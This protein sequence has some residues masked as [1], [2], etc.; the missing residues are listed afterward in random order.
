MPTDMSMSP[1]INAQAQP[2]GPEQAEQI[3]KQRFTE[4][5]YTVLSSRF[6]EL[7]P[8]VVTFKILEVGADVGTGIGVFILD[9]NG[10]SIY[11]PIIMTDSKL[12]PIEM[13]YYKDLNIFLPL[14]IPWLDEVGKMSLDEMG[15]ASELPKEVPQDVN[16]RNVVRPPLSASGRYGYASL[17]EQINH[18]AKYMFKAAEDQTLNVQPQFLNILKNAPK[19][20]LDGVKLAFQ[21]RPFLLQK[22]ANNYGKEG[23]INAMRQGYTQALALEKTAAPKDPG[24]V[25]VLTKEASQQHILDVFGEHAGP[26]FSQMVKL[27]FACKDTRGPLEKIAVKIEGPA[28]L[29]SPGPQPGWYRLYFVDG[30]PEIYYVIP[31]PR[32]DR[33]PYVTA[34]A[35]YGEGLRR[36]PTQ[37]LVVS[38]DG[39]EAWCTDDVMGEKIHNLSEEG[40]KGSKIYGLLDNSKGGG[41]TPTAGSYGFFINVSTTGVEATNLLHI[42]TATTDGD[43]KKYVTKWGDD[44]YIID[45]DP[46]RKNIQGAMQ[47]HLIFLPNTAKFV[48]LLKVGNDADAWTKVNEYNR[49]RKNSVINDPQV[50]T[51]WLTHIMQEAGGRQVNV[52]SAG[53][54]EWWIAGE[55]K[56]LYKAAALEKVASV[57]GISVDD[58]ASILVEANVK[59]RSNAF[60]MDHVSGGR[61]KTAFRKLAQSPM[62]EQPM[63]YESVPGQMQGLPMM[64]DPNAMSPYGGQEMPGQ[65]IMAQG[66]IDPMAP[67]P[68]PSPMSPTDLAIG[69]A[70]QQLQQQQ[71]FEAQETQS[72]MSQMQQQLDMQQQNNDQLIQ[73]LQGIQQRSQEIAQATGGQVPAGAEQSPMVAAQAIAPTPPQEPPPPPMPMMDQESMSPEMIAQ[74]IKPEMVDQ[75]A[76]FNDAGMFDTAA[77]AM[78]AAA[79]VL[80][81]IVSSYVPNLEKA[82]DNLGRVLLTLWMKEEDTKEAIGDEEYIGL[83]DKLRTLFKGMGAVVLTLSHNAVNAQSEAEKAQ[84]MMQNIHG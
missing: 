65:Y 27:G 34:T 58:A 30:N 43:T 7:E 53:L 18:D 9:Y 5:A 24:E 10:K 32:N 2:P 19:V 49:K 52:K 74:Q 46:S 63:S 62:E 75:A 70:V 80:Q 73:V 4:M 56:A 35:S 26:A 66:G 39:K 83:E 8:Y 40:I 38:K 76:A 60:I 61:L 1:G 42:E 69:E 23:V 33:S 51:R 68:P 81:D 15:E 64:G 6:A 78:L 48:Q 21:T 12:K 72:Q 22:L 57:Y 77:I 71:Q 59:G 36:K 28:V 29:D 17:E 79:P 41:D 45:K 11:I 3:F 31:N 50:L 44:T 54:N 20:V 16:L 13:F 37:Y 55:N 67:Q 82:T 47:G 14:S 84:M 25:R